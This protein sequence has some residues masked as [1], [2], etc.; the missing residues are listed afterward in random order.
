ML[1]RILAEKALLDRAGSVGE[2]AVELG[3]DY[4][5]KSYAQKCY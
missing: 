4:V 5:W 2:S 1:H 3:R